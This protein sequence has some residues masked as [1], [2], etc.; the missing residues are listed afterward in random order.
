MYT[1]LQF[2]ICGW[3][4]KILARRSNIMGYFYLYFSFQPN[5][6][7][8]KEMKAKNNTIGQN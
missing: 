3:A 5:R 7:K 2:F 8:N 6:T 4:S 1:E